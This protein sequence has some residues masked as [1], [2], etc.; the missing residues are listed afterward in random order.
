MAE[1]FFAAFCTSFARSMLKDFVRQGLR[2]LLQEEN[3]VIN[4]DNLLYEP[5]K[6]AK[7]HLDTAFST[8]DERRRSEHIENA[9]LSFVKA[10]NLDNPIQAGRAAV[11]VGVCHYLLDEYNNEQQ[12]YAKANERLSR[13]R[14]E[15]IYKACMYGG[16]YAQKLVGLGTLPPIALTTA[17]AVIRPL[18]WFKVEKLMKE[19]G[20]TNEHLAAITCLVESRRQS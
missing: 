6:S 19:L 4:P 16:P 10:S 7:D 1:P 14:G 5:L 8:S 20:E 11:Y 17:P 3:K 18:L 13:H 12:W 9:R 2:E 15:L